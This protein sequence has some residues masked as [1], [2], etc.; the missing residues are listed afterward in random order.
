[1]AIRSFRRSSARRTFAR[2]V[3]GGAFKKCCRNTGNYDGIERD[4]YF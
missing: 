3:P 4:Y 2:A 1:M